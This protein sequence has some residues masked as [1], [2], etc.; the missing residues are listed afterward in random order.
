MLKGLLENGVEAQQTMY[1]KED[2]KIRIIRNGESREVLFHGIIKNA[3]IF[4]ENEVYHIE[5]F[6]VTVSEM[7]DRKKSQKSF[8]DIRMTYKQAVNRILEPYESM[9]ALY[10]KEANE[11]LQEPVIQYGEMDWE[12]LIRL[13]SHLHIPIYADC[14]SGRTILH[15]GMP[16]GNLVNAKF[17]SYH[18]GISQKYHE[19]GKG[20]NNITRKEYLYYIVS[21]DKNYQIG[22][23]LRI[24]MCNY[25]IYQKYAQFIHDKMEFTYWVGE[26]GNWY[27]PYIAHEQLTGMEFAGTVIKTQTDT[28]NICLQV[29]KPYKG[30][31]YDWEWTPTSGNIMYAMPE[32]GTS[33]KLCFGS[34]IASEG[35]ATINVRDNG[36]I[37]HDN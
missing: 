9:T 4:V 33:V 14:L 21:S 29:D 12:F 1:S 30:A 8:Q 34:E 17:D 10:S 37:I 5:I 32:K 18:V 31:E 20:K 36:D 25:V 13:G 15:F 16:Q 24:G 22:D 35:I 2:V 11:R 6:A 3:K 28:T 23:K 19:V 7:L 27:I 26:C